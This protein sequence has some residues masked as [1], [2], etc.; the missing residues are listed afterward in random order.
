MKDIKGVIW[1]QDL[2]ARVVLIDNAIAALLN[3]ESRREEN[4]VF[5]R[6]RE[7]VGQFWEDLAKAA[8]T[9]ATAAG[10]VVWDVVYEVC[11]GDKSEEEDEAIS[12]ATTNTKSKRK[13]AGIDGIANSAYSASKRQIRICEVCKGDR[14]N[15]KKCWAAFLELISEG[16]NPFIAKLYK[17]KVEKV[18][19]NPEMRQK[20]DQICKE[21]VEEKRTRCKFSELPI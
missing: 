7:V 18:L 4:Q 9:K 10:H 20:I 21:L 8:K 12:I 17:N 16:A 15:L 19:K 14:H 1:L 5:K 3:L 6:F 11:L 13:R 2:A